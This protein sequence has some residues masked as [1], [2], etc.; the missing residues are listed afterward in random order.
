[1]ADV[2]VRYVSS[3]QARE[4]FRVGVRVTRVGTSSITF[5]YRVLGGDGRL[6]AEGDSVEVAI[7]PKTRRPRALT[8]EA[9]QLV[10]G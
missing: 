7:D 4:R 6:C 9:R 5:G 10:S 8:A 3:L 2:H 1:V